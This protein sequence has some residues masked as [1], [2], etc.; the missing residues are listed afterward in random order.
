MV[1]SGARLASGMAPVRSPSG[2]RR[3]RGHWRR[4]GRIGLGDLL[5]GD[6]GE[7]RESD[8]GAEAHRDIFID[9]CS[10]L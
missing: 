8:E 1:R 5:L 9:H 4:R 3:G 6:R 2:V 10:F 7:R